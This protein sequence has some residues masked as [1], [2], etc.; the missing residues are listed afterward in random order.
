MWGR[1]RSAI[2]AALVRSLMEAAGGVQQGPHGETGA[3]CCVFSAM[4]AVAA[5]LGGLLLDAAL[6]S[7]LLEEL[8]K[9]VIGKC[10]H[11]AVYAQEADDLVIE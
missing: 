9:R 7:R 5:R 10:D 2:G 8:R 3:A 4:Q 11:D 1:G 6:L